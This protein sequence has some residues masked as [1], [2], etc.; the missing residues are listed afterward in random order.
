MRA[1]AILGLGC[2]AKNLRRFQADTMVEWRIGMPAPGDQVDVILLFG[3]DGT[4]HRHL[5]QL[6]KL[7]I[8]V[9]VVPAGSGNDF[10][11][12]LGLRGVRDSLAAWQTFC[13]GANN[14]RTID[15]GLITPIGADDDQALAEPLGVHNLRLDIFAAW[16]E[17]GSTARFRG[18]PTG[19]RDGC[20]GTAAMR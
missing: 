17:S 7:G 2:S 11:R 5:G 8:P 16:P 18:E 1:A 13:G 9:L 10:A 15:L 3:G 4:V 19:C 6:V 14:V 12:A 20:G